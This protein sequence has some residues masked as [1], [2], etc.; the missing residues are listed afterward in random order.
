MNNE[1]CFNLIHCYHLLYVSCVFF[2][3]FLS[4]VTRQ[5]YFVRGS[6]PADND[7]TIVVEAAFQ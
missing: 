5:Y 2:F 6:G 1:I 7:V 3:N 4:E